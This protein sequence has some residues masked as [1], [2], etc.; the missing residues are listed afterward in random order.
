[1][2]PTT[3]FLTTFKTPPRAA[4]AMTGSAV[5]TALRAVL[6]AIAIAAALISATVVLY[7]MKSALG[8]NLL[9]GHSPLHDL[10]YEFV[11]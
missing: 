6:S 3:P 2:T 11:R 1:M 7:L 9:P 8:I 10:L 4:E 5:M